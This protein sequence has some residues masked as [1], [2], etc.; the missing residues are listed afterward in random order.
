A[1]TGI[2]LLQTIGAGILA[3]VGGAVAILLGLVLL[4]LSGGILQAVVSLPGNLL[5]DLS[6]H[7]VRMLP[8]MV[9]L[10]GLLVVSGINLVLMPASTAVLY[11]G[12]SFRL[13]REATGRFALGGPLLGLVGAVGVVGGLAWADRQKEHLNV[14][15]FVDPSGDADRLALMLEEEPLRRALVDQAL[16]SY[17]YLGATEDADFLLD[18]W[19]RELGVEA[20]WP[21][22]TFNLLIHPLLYEGSL[23][24][25]ES[26]TARVF[27]GQLFDQPFDKAEREALR[28][29]MNAT[30]DRSSAKA[31]LSDIDKKTVH[32]EKQSLSW[33]EQNSLAV[34]TLDEVYANTS[35]AVQEIHLSFSMPESAAFT[36]LWLSDDATQP[37]KYPAVLAP[38]GAAQATYDRIRERGSDPAILEQVGPRQYRLRVF[39]I[40]VQRG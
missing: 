14:P 7:D 8:T 25:Q 27:Y 19:R 20:T 30:W 24:E 12:T 32:L 29:A 36:G 21:Q 33:V 38:R 17:R 9:A 4:P 26:E 18:L 13:L 40:P 37:E 16:A 35:E 22:D 23:R 34:V 28:T 5:R 39:P 3:V 2:G 11:L 10:V 6:L 1:A 15:E 31:G